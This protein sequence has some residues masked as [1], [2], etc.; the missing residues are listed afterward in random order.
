M[1]LQ[2]LFTLELGNDNLF[3]NYECVFFD[4]GD[5]IGLA[6]SGSHDNL[7]IKF[8]EKNGFERECITVNLPAVSLP[9]RWRIVHDGNNQLLLCPVSKQYC[10]SQEEKDSFPAGYAFLLKGNSVI[11]A[12]YSNYS[13]CCCS[14]YSKC[15]NP[16]EFGEYTII[17]ESQFKYS[18]YRKNGGQKVWTQ[19]LQGY[20]YRDIVRFDDIVIIKTAGMGGY[21]YGINIENGNIV[22]KI[23]TGDSSAIAF[24]G[25]NLYTLVRGKS[26]KLLVADIHTG[27][28]LCSEMGFS[29]NSYCSIGVIGDLVAAVTCIINKDEWPTAAIQCFTTRSECQGDGSLDTKLEGNVSE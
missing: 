7:I 18:C 25:S 8:I 10:I 23:N 21:V 13:G 26:G 20:L 2:K 3:F 15:P 5:T 9:S 16:Y 29:V 28:I 17:H 27:E 4:A 6:Y 14:G 22:Y 24:A 1:Q 19:V 12:D 11:Q